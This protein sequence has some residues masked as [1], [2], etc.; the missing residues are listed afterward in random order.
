[1][2]RLF[3]AV[4]VVGVC[5]A[6]APAPK[7]SA[8]GYKRIPGYRCMML[9]LTEQQLASTSTHVAVRSAPS[10]EAPEVGWAGDVVVVKEPVQPTNGFLQM[11]FPTGRTVWIAQSDVRPYKSLSDPGATC[12]PEFLPNGRVGFGPA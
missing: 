3:V 6:I 10:V 2:R 11:L 12:V 4:G 1:M 8:A 9:N 7:A 5:L